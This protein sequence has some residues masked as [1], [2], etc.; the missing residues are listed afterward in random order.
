MC[1]NQKGH[2][3]K[4]VCIIVMQCFIIKTF[5]TEVGLSGDMGPSDGSLGQSVL[6]RL[7]KVVY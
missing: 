5:E 6:V 2:K 1:G 3:G 4:N 7:N